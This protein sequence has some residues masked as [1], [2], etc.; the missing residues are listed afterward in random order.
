VLIREI[1]VYLFTY[2]FARNHST[3]SANACF[4]GVCGKPNSRIALAG[5]K[6]IRCNA[7][8]TPASGARGGRPV[9]FDFNSSPT[10][11]THATPYGI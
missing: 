9:N 6:N 11:A 4:G 2:P 5:L 3:A 10:A 1:R 7:M 8:R